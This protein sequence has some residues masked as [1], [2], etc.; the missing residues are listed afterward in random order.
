MR[1][2]IA[3]SFLIDMLRK[4]TLGAVVTT[5]RS[6]GGV[7]VTAVLADEGFVYGDGVPQYDIM[8]I[9]IVKDYN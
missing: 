4:E 2:S 8:S 5:T 1:Q 7:F 9:L 3:R 6:V